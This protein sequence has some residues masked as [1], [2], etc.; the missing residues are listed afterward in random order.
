MYTEIIKSVVHS[1]NM[2]NQN[3][4]K[5]GIIYE[6]E[7]VTCSDACRNNAVRQHGRDADRRQKQKTKVMPRQKEALIRERIPKEKQFL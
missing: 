3:R 2:E 7:E 1:Y 6:T 5:E 4:L